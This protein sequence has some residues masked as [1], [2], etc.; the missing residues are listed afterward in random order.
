MRA[1]EIILL[2]RPAPVEPEVPRRFDILYEDDS[3]MVIDK[4]A[5]LPMHTTAKFWRNTLV[6]LLREL[7][8]DE[9]DGD[10]ASHRPRDV[11]ACC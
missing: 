9:T 5:G 6:A 8:P 3:V 2:R 7:Y 10:R 4:P 11:R 1:G